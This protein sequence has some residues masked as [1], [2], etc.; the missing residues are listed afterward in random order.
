M[1]T[2][3]CPFCGAMLETP[4]RF[5][6]ECERPVTPDDLAHAGL[7]L[8]RQ[9]AHSGDG[10]TSASS[11]RQFA[12]SRKDHTAQRQMRS[13]FYTTSTVLALMIGYY[14]TMKYVLHEHMPGGLDTKLETLF[15]GQPVDWSDWKTPP[16]NPATGSETPTQTSSN[17]R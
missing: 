5:C 12:L 1:S 15:A 14:C 4:I 3:A 2:I 9:N 13:M 6:K 10:A 17:G 11:S 7:K 8:S 16:K